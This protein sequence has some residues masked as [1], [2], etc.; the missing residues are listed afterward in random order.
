MHLD[1]GTLRDQFMAYMAEDNLVKANEVAELIVDL[2]KQSYNKLGS[3]YQSIRHEGLSK[4]KQELWDRTLSLTHICTAQIRCLDVG[5]GFGKDVYYGNKVLGIKTYGIDNS[6][7]F[8]NILK[9]RAKNGDFDESLIYKGD[10]RNM[11]CFCNGFFHVVWCNAS[12][13]HLP[14]TCPG[15]MADLAVSEFYRVLQKE[16]L[17]FLSLKYGTGLQII[18]TGEKLGGRFYQLYTEDVLKELL[19]RNH[20]DICYTERVKRKRLDYYIDWINVI[21]RKSTLY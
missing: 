3:T 6:D 4:W 1:M 7:S 2:T 21:A 20:F 12:L 9:T 10:M 19:G 5:A 8:F 17:L 11:D 13:L 14:L 16:G 15:H 18:D